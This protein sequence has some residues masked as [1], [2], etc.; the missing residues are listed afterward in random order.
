M[1]DDVLLERI[2]RNLIL[3]AIRYTNH[4]H[5]TLRSRQRGDMLQIQ[6]RDTGI[7]IPRNDLRRIF[8]AFYQVDNRARDRRKGLGLGLAIV[9]QL[10]DLLGHRIKVKTKVGRGTVFLLSV[11]LCT[12]STLMALQRPSRDRLGRDYVRGAFVILI[13]DD[14]LSR[15]ASEHTLKAFGCRVITASSGVEAIEKLQ[16]Q[17]FAPQLIVADYRLEAETGIEA[18]RS[19]TENLQVLFGETFSI[20]A[21]V[22]S[23]DTAPDELRQVNEHG[24]PMLHKPVATEDLWGALNRLLERKAQET[25]F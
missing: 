2:L 15:E 9:R 4:G 18:I 11:P 3:N 14:A 25:E 23:G 6:V 24:Y 21:V 20:P 12:D 16:H 13:D 17:E 7:G 22:V 19:V 8:D 5:V 1:S 10:C